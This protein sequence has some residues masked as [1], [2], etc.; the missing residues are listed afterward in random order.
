MS[1]LEIDVSKGSSGKSPKAHTNN[2]TTTQ[3]DNDFTKAQ[4][5]TH[6]ICEKMDV[7]VTSFDAKAWLDAVDEY[8]NVHKRIVYTAI[9][10]YIYN[11]FANTK[12]GENTEEEFGTIFSNLDAASNY[13]KDHSDEFCNSDLSKIIFKIYDHSNLAYRQLTSLANDDE[14]LNQIAREKMKPIVEKI[15]QEMPSQLI[16]LVS[17]FTALSFVIFGGISSLDSILTSVSS[18]SDSILPSIIVS[19]CWAFCIFNLLV[20]FMKYVLKIIGKENTNSFNLTEFIQKNP[21]WIFMNFGILVSLLVC[22]VAHYCIKNNIGQNIYK[23]LIDE[24]GDILFII[25][26]ILTALVIGA[27]WWKLKNIFKDNFHVI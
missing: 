24:N 2:E 12:K 15:N 23:Y 5:A 16:G 9:S 22:S 10:T 25:I 20:L 4:I 27:L 14:K 1:S 6:E 11:K 19:L 26:V 13:C 3:S 8:I 17:I 7:S 18:N 21:A